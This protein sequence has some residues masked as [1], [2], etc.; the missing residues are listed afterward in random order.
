MNLKGKINKLLNN[1]W[2]LGGRLQYV[3][4]KRIVIYHSIERTISDNTNIFSVLE[5]D[6]Y[7][8]IRW[9]KESSGLEIVDLQNAVS[10]K[11]V[12]ITFD[13]GYFSNYQYA[14]PILEELQVPA[15]FFITTENIEMSHPDYLTPKAIK[16]IAERHQFTIGSH[17]H[18]HPRLSDCSDERICYELSRS[19]IFLERLIEQEV[20]LLSYPHGSW[21]E[22]VL[23]IAKSLGYKKCY[24]SRIGMQKSG[25]NDHAIPRCCIIRS[26]KLNGFESRICGHNDWR[27]ILQR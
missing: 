24:T 7:N 9:L 8:Q 15:T 20:S 17:S 21:D 18:S 3:N 4:G 12:S 26:D 16:E 27:G 14:L 23:R 13:D 6:F 5:T 19:K 2:S 22:R 10:E 25:T 1:F 11:T